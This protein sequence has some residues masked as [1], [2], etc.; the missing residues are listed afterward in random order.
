MPL[1]CTLQAA[2][3]PVLGGWPC[4]PHPLPVHSR[5]QCSRQLCLLY[6]QAIV[7]IFT[8]ETSKRRCI[9]ALCGF[10]KSLVLLPQCMPTMRIQAGAIA[11]CIFFVAITLHFCR[12][13]CRHVNKFRPLQTTFCMLFSSYFALHTQTKIWPKS[14][15]VLIV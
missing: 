12:P 6:F 15:K 7:G 2:T 14:Q 4:P 8:C 3:Q 9:H 10:F 13:P 5:I 11:S 1:P